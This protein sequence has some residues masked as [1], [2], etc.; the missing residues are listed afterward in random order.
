[1]ALIFLKTKAIPGRRSHP[2]AFMPAERQ[3]KEMLFSSAE[4]MEGSGNF[5]RSF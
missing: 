3:K 5:K 2:I 4:T 1:M